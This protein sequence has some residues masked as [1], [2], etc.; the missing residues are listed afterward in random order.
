M[1]M[2]T[3]NRT[4]NESKLT[5]A[6]RSMNLLTTEESAERLGVTKRRVQAMIRDGRLPAEKMGRDWFI[7]EEDLALVADRKPGRPTQFAIFGSDYQTVSSESGW[8]ALTKEKQE[9]RLFAEVKK[10]DAE[11]NTKRAIPEGRENEYMRRVINAFEAKPA[12]KARAKKTGA[13]KASKK[14]T[15]G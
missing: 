14:A 11:R 3:Q 12:L 9:A 1:H 10:R 7:R 2:P 4:T 6:K 8:N 5:S 15:R 13:K